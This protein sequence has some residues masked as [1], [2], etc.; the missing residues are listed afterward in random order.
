[1]LAQYKFG[2]RFGQSLLHLSPPPRKPRIVVGPNRDSLTTREKLLAILLLLSVGFG[3][4][5]VGHRWTLQSNG[6]ARTRVAELGRELEAA[7]QEAETLKQQ[8]AVAER[9]DQVTRGAN[10]QL[11][12]EY[13]AMQDELAALRADIEFYQRLLGSASAGNGLAVHGLQLI[14]T[15][16]PLVYRFELTLS[17]NLKKARIVAGE[18]ELLVD[19][20]EGDQLRTLDPNTLD[21]GSGKGSI[22]FEFKYFQLLRGSF[23]L[24]EGFVAERIRVHLTIG[25]GRNGESQWREFNWSELIETDT[26]DKESV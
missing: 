11:R 15:S 3:G 13:V 4:A 7:R 21:L 23:A 6:D 14:R 18:A 1:V 25:K 17:Q 8:L 9:G 2:P 12:D 10:D 5:L 19:G 16:S 22:G 20:V 24:P 26:A